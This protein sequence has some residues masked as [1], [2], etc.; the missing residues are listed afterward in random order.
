M[1]T[2]FDHQRPENR[3]RG[4]GSGGASAAARGHDEL[5]RGHDGGGLLLGRRGADLHYKG[6]LPC[7]RFGSSSRLVRSISRPAMSLIRVSAGSITSS[8]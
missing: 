2:G 7:L 6:T 3:H 1:G 4:D 5:D 8:T